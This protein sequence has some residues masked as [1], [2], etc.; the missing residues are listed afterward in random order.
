MEEYI[1]SLLE[2]ALLEEY[3]PINK[4]IDKYEEIKNLPL[5]SIGVD[6]IAFLEIYMNFID[7]IN[8]NGCREEVEITDIRTI[9]GMERIIERCEA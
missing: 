4:F 8:K 5:D 6:S 2:G 7:G 1:Y 3:K 9:R